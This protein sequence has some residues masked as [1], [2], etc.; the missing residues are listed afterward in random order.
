MKSAGNG[1]DPAVVWPE[2]KDF[3]FTIFDDTDL[4]TA[5]N[6]KPVYD[7]LEA[8]GFRTTKSVW[9]IAGT[10]PAR[11]DGGTC[12]DAPY[13]AWTR[14]LQDR[15]FEIG[16]HNAT[17]HTSAREK[18]ERALAEFEGL[19]GHVPRVHANHYRNLE[20]IYW[21][22]ARLTGWR[23]VAYRVA[24]RLRP[25]GPFEGHVE[26]SPLFWGDLCR[27]TIT[28]VRNFVF[29]DINTL[30]A[31]PVMPYADPAKPYVR[32][33]FASSEGGTAATF[34]RTLSEE[35]QDRLEEEGGA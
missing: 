15:G 18:T 22:D 26:S 31:C 7:L 11:I 25:F 34:L 29:D 28:Y 23:R 17:Y 5:E 24:T 9:P 3:A 16:L 8:L 6:V 32:R 10:H 4:Q 30:R 14:T 20:G 21:G 35:N 27:D 33:W 1:A 13:R 2:G 19:Y 12:A